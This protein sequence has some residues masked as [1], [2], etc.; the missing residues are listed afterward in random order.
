MVGGNDAGGISTY[1]SQV[2][3]RKPILLIDVDKKSKAAAIS[4]ISNLALTGSK[5][6]VGFLMNSVSVT[7]EAA[8]SGLD[9]L[10]AIIAFVSV[11]KSGK[12]A[13]ERHSYGHGKIE[14]LSGVLEALLIF[15]AAGYIVYEA[16]LKLSKGDFQ[17]EDLGLGAAVMGGSAIIN[18]FVS[19]YLYRVAHET[20][21]I[22]LEADALHLRTDVYT[23]AGVL[24]GLLAIRFTGLKILDPLFAIAVALLILKAAYDLSGNAVQN[25]LDIR[26]PDRE[27]DLIRE[28][29]LAN[30]S[31][32]VEF[33]KLRTRKSGHI[34]YIDF[35]MVVA[36]TSS[37]EK[38]HQL[39]HAVVD[40]IKKLLPNSHVLVHAE[41]CHEQCAECAVSCQDSNPEK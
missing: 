31:S 35:H 30:S 28:V 4:I 14:S 12:P 34:R 2:P 9:L 38:C 37:I 41:P 1:A 13:D 11:R 20:E 10:A 19:N 26:L 27:E 39:S 7:A 5:F 16:G 17:I 29:L 8:H 33:H 40:E 18:F 36:R 25:I 23:S 22:A 15:A 21:S 32:I 24:A 3:E 6:A